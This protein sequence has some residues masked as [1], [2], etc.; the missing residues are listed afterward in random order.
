MGTMYLWIGV[1]GTTLS[2]RTLR[3]PLPNLLDFSQYHFVNQL[4]KFRGLFSLLTLCLLDSIP[5][6]Y[7][8]PTAFIYSFSPCRVTNDERSKFVP[9]LIKLAISKVSRCLF[10]PLYLHV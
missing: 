6:R 3:S 10:P 9:E 2:G 8:Y 1:S 4:P 5:T 7:L